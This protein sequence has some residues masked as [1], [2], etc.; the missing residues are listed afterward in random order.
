MAV[1]NL[2]QVTTTLDI[3][4]VAI[5]LVAWQAAIPKLSS[6]KAIA[7]PIPVTWS[8]VTTESL[9]AISTVAITNAK[10]PIVT[11]MLSSLAVTALSGSTPVI[12]KIA[13]LGTAMLTI[14]AYAQAMRAICSVK[15]ASRKVAGQWSPKSRGEPPS[16]RAPWARCTCGQRRPLKKPIG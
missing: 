11:L 15:L 3:V 13:Q 6:H 7:K 16:Y 4:A 14:R 2:Q 5:I 1:H 8:A 10:K 9:V 12:K